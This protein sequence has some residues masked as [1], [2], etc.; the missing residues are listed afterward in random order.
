MHYTPLKCITPFSIYIMQLT[1]CTT[2]IALT[3]SS[4]ILSAIELTSHFKLTKHYT[5]QAGEILSSFHVFVSAFVCL[6]LGLSPCLLFYDSL[7]LLVSC[8]CLCLCLFVSRSLPV[9]LVL[10]FPLSPPSMFLSLPLSVCLS[11]S[12]RVSW[13]MIPSLSISDPE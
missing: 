1:Q 11:V 3:Q 4:S 13:S 12:P 8:F 6:S 2:H 7:S 9:S 5:P 10:W